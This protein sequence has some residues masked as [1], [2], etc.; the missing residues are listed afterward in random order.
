MPLTK[1]HHFTRNTRLETSQ[2][3]KIGGAPFPTRDEIARLAYAYWEERGKPLGSAE[4]DWVRA[5]DELGARR[6]AGLLQG[7]TVRPLR[8]ALRELETNRPPVSQP[9]I[10]LR[11]NQDRHGASGA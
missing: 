6:E 2:E 3:T 10:R 1:K 5:E 8:L 9:S 11:Q 7:E 4:A